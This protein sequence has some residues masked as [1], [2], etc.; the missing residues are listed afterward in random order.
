[1]TFHPG[2]QS[3][4]ISAHGAAMAPGNLYILYCGS[5][6][7]SAK[8]ASRLQEPRLLIVNRSRR[9]KKGSTR[10]RWKKK[11]QRRQDERVDHGLAGASRL[12]DFSSSMMVPVE[13]A[14]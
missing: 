14:C 10:L 11:G 3:R 1:M 9:A 12:L 4:R 7:G 2:R 6:C 13:K 8:G 5:R